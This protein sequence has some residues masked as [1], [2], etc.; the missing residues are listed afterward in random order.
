MFYYFYIFIYK[1]VQTFLED[2]EGPGLKARADFPIE[3]YHEKTKASS[4]P[5]KKNYI[6][7]P[8]K[9]RKLRTE[10]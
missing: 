5:L 3:I 1:I 6:K 7:K 8:S 10:G 9:P 2:M 4:L